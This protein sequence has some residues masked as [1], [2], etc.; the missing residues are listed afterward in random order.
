[1]TA[2]IPQYDELY[3]ISDLHLGGTGPKG[4]IFCRGQRLKL[5]LQRLAAKPGPIALV[6]AGDLFDSLPHL[7]KTNTYIAVDGA[8]GLIEAIMLDGSFAPVFDG[9]M[10]FLDNDGRELIV[11]IGNHD[12]EIALMEAQNVLLERIAPTAAARGRV[13]FSVN[14]VGFRCHVGRRTV[15]VTH[16]NEADPWN[17][18][19][20]EAL[21]RASHARALGQPFDAPS[22]MPNAGTML[23]VDVMNA[24]KT[25]HPFIDLLKPEREAA[26]NILSILAPGTLRSCIDAL[27]ALA[28]AAAAHAGPGV[29]LGGAAEI[30]PPALETARLL[31][32]AARRAFFA[33][34]A[35]A[36]ALLERVEHLH[37]NGDSPVNLVSDEDQLLALERTR[38]VIDRVFGRHQSHAL[39]RALRSWIKD[40]HSFTLDHRDSTCTR[41]LSQLGS[42]VDV[43]VTGHTHL[44]RWIDAVERNVVYLNAGAWARV[45]GL[46]SEFLDTDAAFA[47]VWQ[48]LKASDLTVL[49]TTTIPTATG[50]LPLVLDATIAAHVRDAG[51]VAELVRVTDANLD[52]QT[53]DRSRSVLDWR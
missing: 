38:Y 28:A 2:S 24:I 5:F 49:D 43:V 46:R 18:V 25:D 10:T 34:D 19:D 7:A 17:R 9:L 41:V 32:G 30:S 21:R 45:I 37:E 39:R 1:M 15:Y 27:P 12:L 44:P 42:G 47:P 22:W 11:L 16:G 8:A 35:S 3:S 20:H 51:L 50:G 52:G 4:Q 14:G 53:V 31:G 29:V 33:P 48:A 6:I 36:T 40:D 23:V 13:R 26:V